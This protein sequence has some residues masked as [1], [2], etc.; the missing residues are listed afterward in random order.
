MAPLKIHCFKCKSKTDSVGAT[1]H[2]TKK[3][4]AMIKASCRKCKTRKCMMVKHGGDIWGSIK[5]GLSAANDA[6]APVLKT[7]QPYLQTAATVAP[8]LL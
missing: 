7:A 3:G 4:G 2:T 5:D 1:R 6:V 8:L